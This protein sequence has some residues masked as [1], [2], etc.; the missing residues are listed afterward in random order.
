MLLQVADF[1]QFK[2]MMMFY[3]REKEEEE[4]KHSGEQLQGITT[5]GRDVS[6]IG[7]VE[8]MMN[9]CAQLATAADNEGWTNCLSLD[10]MTIDKKAVEPSKRK[11]KNDIYLRGVWTMNITYEEACDMMFE[12]DSKRRPK[13]DPNFKSCDL[14]GGS[15]YDDDLI[16][17]AVMDFGYLTNLV[18]F[19][20][21]TGLTLST[22]NFKRWN[23]PRKVS[24]PPI[25]Y[26]S[27]T[28]ILFLLL[29]QS[30]IHILN[31]FFQ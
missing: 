11:T 17:T 25:P 18:M 21:S 15:S 1:E 27:L 10:W 5:G 8:G 19:Q 6:M 16:A 31:Q 23:Q 28:F 24:L 14:Y 29:Q 20:N 22:R 26:F 13:W 3:R 9:M 4:G 30:Q 2:T 12:F 7:D